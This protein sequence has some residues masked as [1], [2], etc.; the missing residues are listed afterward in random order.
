MKVGGHWVKVII[1]QSTQ[2]KKVLESGNKLPDS[3]HNFTPNTLTRSPPQTDLVADVKAI[4]LDTESEPPLYMQLE[5]EAYL[6]PFQYSPA[7]DDKNGDSSGMTAAPYV[8]RQH[9][10]TLDTCW[11]EEAADPKDHSNPGSIVPGHDELGVP[12]LSRTYVLGAIEIAQQKLQEAIQHLQDDND[13]SNLNLD[14]KRD[15]LVEF[16]SKLERALSSV[17]VQQ[18]MVDW[19]NPLRLI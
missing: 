13:W 10:L 16:M 4:T 8:V 18:E 12:T 15:V 2:E 17:P 1:Q 11:N 5:L 9:Q 14:D 19:F 3:V 7:P 6:P